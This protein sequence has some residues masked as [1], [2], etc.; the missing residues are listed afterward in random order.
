M[1]QRALRSTG[2]TENETVGRT[3][4]TGKKG[5]TVGG[6]KNSERR[7]KRGKAPKPAEGRWQ[8]I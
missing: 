3:L 6:K 4:E 1:N 2:R 8:R 5:E 7:G